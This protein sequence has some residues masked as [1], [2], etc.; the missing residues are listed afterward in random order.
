MIFGYLGRYYKPIEKSEPKTEKETETVQK[1]NKA[2]AYWNK[3]R[4]GT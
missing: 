2:E 4:N 1:M 3:V